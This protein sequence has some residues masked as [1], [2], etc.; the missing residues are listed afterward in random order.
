[1]TPEQALQL[2]DNAASM[3]QVNRQDHV[4]IVRAVEILKEYLQS[5]KI[6]TVIDKIDTLQ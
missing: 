3:A 5:K 1:M 2:L 6:N 4:N